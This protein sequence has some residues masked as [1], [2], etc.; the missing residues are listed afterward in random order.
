MFQFCLRNSIPVKAD[1]NISI[2][3]TNLVEHLY[4]KYR[5]LGAKDWKRTIPSAAVRLKHADFAR[6]AN[7]PN[8][9]PL[10]TQWV[11]RVGRNTHRGPVIGF[12]RLQQRHL[13]SP[14]R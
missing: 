4:A 3:L 7:E 12:K 2:T 14:Q 11:D 1:W 6:R 10:S 13:L 9:Q 5:V 8:L